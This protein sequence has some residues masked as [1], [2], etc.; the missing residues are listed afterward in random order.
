VIKPLR[1]ELQR[2]LMPI[3]NVIFFIV[4]E[5]EI[6]TLTQ[7]YLLNK[8][9]QDALFVLDFFRI[10]CSLHVSNRVT[11]HQGAVTVY[12]AYGIYHAFALT[13]S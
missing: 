6:H 11:I 13:S 3:L 2:R 1:V 5:S 8:E 10:I 4:Q 9:E 12:A 7:I